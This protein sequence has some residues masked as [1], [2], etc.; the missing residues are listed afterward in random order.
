MSN[1]VAIAEEADSD[2]PIFKEPVRID[3]NMVQY[4]HDG[5]VTRHVVIRLPVGVIADHLNSNRDLFNRVQ[6]T[7]S[8]ALRK[9]D[10]LLLIS[11]EEDWCADVMVA[12]AS[13]T[14]ITLAKPIITTLPARR[15][16]L[17]QDDTYR[18][19]WGGIGYFVHRKSDNFTMS[20]P[21]ATPQIAQAEL[22]R[23]Y[24]VQLPA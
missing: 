2:E 9:F 18:V 24:P 8:K 19:A 16:N 13:P 11:Y 21:H 14:G 22:A 10:R 20:G 7:R 3:P 4:D 5:M 17:F 15:E 12:E 1:A 23:L 6:T